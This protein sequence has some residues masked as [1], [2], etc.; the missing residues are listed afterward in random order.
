[1]RS[2]GACL[3]GVL[4]LSAC[5]QPINRASF[6]QIENDMS[7]AE[8]LALLGEP[9]QSRTMGLGEIS[10]TT[11]VWQGDETKISVVFANDRVVLKTLVP[12]R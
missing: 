6:E 5:G 12:V 11:A 1:M 4:L 3:L 2:L 9:D 8:V 10:G 7:R